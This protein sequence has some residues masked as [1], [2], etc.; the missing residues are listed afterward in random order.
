MSYLPTEPQHEMMKLDSLA[1]LKDGGEMGALIRGFN[2]QK[3]S[4][5]AITHWPQALRTIVSMMLQ[6]PVPMVL[7]WG[8]DGIMIYNDP[9]SG[10]A[11]G[12]HPFLLGSKVIEGWPEVADFNRNVMDKGLK[13]Q[14]LSYRDQ[15]LTLYRNNTPEEVWMDLNYSPILDEFGEPAG[16]LAIV[17]ETTQR[18]KAELAL[19][20]SE[21]RFRTMSDTAPLFIWTSGPDGNTNYV[22]KAWQDFL[23][24]PPEKAIEAIKDAMLP[25]ERIITSQ[26]YRKA[27]EKRQSYTLE[28]Q[29]KR[30]DGKRRWFLTKGSPLFLASGELAGYIGTSIDITDRKETETQLENNLAQEKLLRK[31][32]QIIGQSFDTDS[33]LQTVAGELGEYLQA[34]RCAIN[35]FS[36]INGELILNL[37]A[38]YAREGCK[39]VDPEDVKRI[40]EAFRHLDPNAINEE[41]EQITYIPNPEQYIEHLRREMAKIADQLKGLTVDN[42]I[43]IVKKYDIQSSLRVNIHYRGAPYGSISVSQCSYQR[44]WT[45]NEIELIKIIAEHAGGAIYQSE[46]YRQ[47]QETALK[48]QHARQDMEIYAKRLEA[49][50][51]E[52]EQFATIAS[53]DL[54]EPLRKIQVLSEM[55]ESRVPNSEKD[56]FNRISS[57][58]NRMRALM[59][60]LLTL[61][62]VN[63][64]GRPF[65]TVDLN[66]VITVVLDD[67]QIPMQQAQAKIYVET[68]DLVQGDETQIRQL[69]QNLIGNAIKYH[70]SN[71]PPIV[72]IFGK[73]DENQYSV[74]VED[75]GI[76]IAKEH[77]SRIFEPFQRLHGMGQYPGT[78][79]GLAICRKIVERHGGTLTIESD[80]QQGSRF[81]LSLPT[82]Q[83]ASLPSKS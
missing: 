6:S 68:L 2:W 41:K 77:W 67:L 45:E 24:T 37:S 66:A 16:V 71:I 61:S 65:Q 73:H 26:K 72:R 81:T 25:D 10:F 55:L 70:R 63:R 60:D 36:I 8:K 27:F 50:N 3:T 83:I 44:V 32:V 4:I 19:R 43:D 78:G 38:Q 5:G 18:V 54:S 53:H 79:M 29:F 7:L 22:N 58:A 57:A 15:R 39:P 80:L 35:R 48:E 21:T 14:T 52:L 62:R 33:I 75:N 1:W 40:V 30:H 11:G 56:Y 82:T 51:K 28:N 34:D 9:Y 23:G 69:F 74:C 42:L 17:V 76:G 46:L 13:G 49:S 31:I 12:R 47:A 59:D 64:K 20:E